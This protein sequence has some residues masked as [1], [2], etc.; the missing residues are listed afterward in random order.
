MTKKY[1]VLKDVLLPIEHI[2][3]PFFIPQELFSKWEFVKGAK[4]IHKVNKKT[5]QAYIFKEGKVPFPDDINKPARTIV[6]TEGGQYVAREKHVI[7]QKGRY[8]RLHPIE[9]ERLNG[10]PDDFTKCEGILESQR[11]FF[12][13]NA[14]V[15]GVVK[16]LGQEL[17][18]AVSQ[19]KK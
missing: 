15:I 7:I 5:G 6:T 10:F 1:H 14:L 8:R 19:H 13:G 17:S 9:L 18:N 16:R 4:A 12:M 2:P 11:A 3:D